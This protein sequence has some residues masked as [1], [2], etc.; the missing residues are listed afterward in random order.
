MR[1]HQDFYQEVNT[2]APF[3]ERHRRFIEFYQGKRSEL[4]RSLRVLDIGC[5]RQTVLRDH[6]D[7]ADHYACCDIVEAPDIPLESYK[8]VDL[9][10]ESLLDYWTEPFDVIFCGELLEHLFDP[11]A[12]VEQIHDLLSPRGVAIISTPNLAYW[13]NRILLL[14]GLSPLF[15]ENSSRAKL[16]RRFSF[17]GEGGPTEGHIR[18]FTHRSLRSLVERCGLAVRLASATTVWSN[19]IDRALSRVAPK[20]APDILFVVQRP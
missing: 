13:A 2:A 17:L 14:V 10:D 5:G 15:L 19:P 18:L 3:T 7:P 9:S 8:K 16:G 11:D 12:L 6:I 20:L 1:T 4:G